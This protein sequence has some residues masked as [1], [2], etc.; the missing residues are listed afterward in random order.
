MPI[1]VISEQSLLSVLDFVAF[2]SNFLKTEETLKTYTLMWQNI[3][4][5]R[6]IIINYAPLFFIVM[7]III[8]YICFFFCCTCL[9]FACIT[10]GT[11]P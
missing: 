11:S 4:F 5:T 1:Q 9:M 6:T 7:I 2:L 10:T 3:Q 8:F